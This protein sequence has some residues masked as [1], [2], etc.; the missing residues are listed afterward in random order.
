MKTPASI[1][2][3]LLL[4]FLFVFS[5][6]ASCTCGAEKADEEDE[7][8]VEVSWDDLWA[9]R[10]E[11]CMRVFDDCCNLVEDEFAYMM[12]NLVCTS[13]KESFDTDPSHPCLEKVFNDFF[14]CCCEICLTDQTGF[15]K[16]CLP[17]F[18]QAFNECVE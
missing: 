6:P 17:P 7:D 3:I 18:V 16:D 15:F 5:L 10:Y 8:I 1:S 2:R 4:L 11:E 12:L 9:E 14:D 13:M